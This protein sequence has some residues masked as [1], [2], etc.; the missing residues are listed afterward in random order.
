MYDLRVVGAVGAWL[1]LHGRA[2]ERVSPIG[3]QSTCLRDGRKT[4]ARKD[5]RA[6]TRLLLQ[7][8]DLAP[9]AKRRIF[10]SAERMENRRGP[11]TRTTRATTRIGKVAIGPRS[12]E[13]ESAASTR[14]PPHPSSGATGR[15]YIFIGGMMA[16]RMLEVVAHGGF[17]TILW[18]GGKTTKAPRNQG[19][20]GEL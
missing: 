15:W 2:M 13:R 5:L 19:N 9:Q 12:N 17:D 8:R 6:R 16:E 3:G 1:G 20:K 11:R 4:C 7:T 14:T 18:R 10:E